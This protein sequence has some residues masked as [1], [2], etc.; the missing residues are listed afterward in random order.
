VLIDG[1]KTFVAFAQLDKLEQAERAQ[2]CRNL[3]QQGFV[4]MVNN[5]YRSRTFQR[6]VILSGYR[7]PEQDANSRQ[8]TREA[9]QNGQ[10]RSIAQ[11][12]PLFQVQGF[13]QTMAAKGRTQGSF[14]YEHTY[15]LS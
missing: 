13:L 3:F 4:E 14:F 1:F 5:W 6:Y 12:I 9:P 2:E 7:S 11:F 10:L 8:P 15:S